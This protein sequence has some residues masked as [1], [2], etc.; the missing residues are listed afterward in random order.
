M[1]SPTNSMQSR[2]KN[3]EDKDALTPL[4]H[5]AAATTKPTPHR[6]GP[7]ATK[8]NSSLAVYRNLLNVTE[9]KNVLQVLPLISCFHWR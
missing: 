6:R 2:L 7:S 8:D 3:E 9:V 1:L 5:S 4:K